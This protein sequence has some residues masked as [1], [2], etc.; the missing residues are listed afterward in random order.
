LFV[1]TTVDHAPA[2]R[3]RSTFTFVGEKLISVRYA[4]NVYAADIPAQRFDDAELSPNFTVSELP[5][6]AASRT[7]CNFALKGS[8]GNG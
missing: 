2:L 5:V 6:S 1:C 4:I 7:S 3:A 8:V